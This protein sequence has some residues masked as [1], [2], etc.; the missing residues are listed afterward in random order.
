MRRF[1]SLSLVALVFTYFAACGGEEAASPIEPGGVAPTLFGAL[2]AD[3]YMAVG[4]LDLVA[5]RNSPMGTAFLEKIAKANPAAQSFDFS[6]IRRAALAMKFD[7]RSWPNTWRAFHLI[8]ALEASL[9]SDEFEAMLPA[10]SFERGNMSFAT[11]FR[12]P[13]AGAM[14]GSPDDDFSVAFAG[15]GVVLLGNDDNLIM[16]SMAA[17][18]GRATRLEDDELTKTRLLDN[19]DMAAPGWFVMRMGLDARNLLKMLPPFEKCVARLTAE[20]ALEGLAVFSFAEAEG[21]R[22]MVAGHDVNLKNMEKYSSLIAES[23]G[24][25]WLEFLNKME[26]NQTGKM[27]V[28]R[29]GIDDAGLDELIKM[30][31]ETPEEDAAEDEEVQ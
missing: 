10:G 2:A 21:A 28:F 12:F 14:F 17:M 4:H 24:E 5:L 25:A 6:V 23:G 15:S 8:V 13:G 16:N 20:D 18:G 11:V 26:V 22:R 31:Q 30:P 3:D 29:V 9:T 27:A 1:F 19:A 7:S